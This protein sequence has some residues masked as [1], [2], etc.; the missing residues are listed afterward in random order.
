STTGQSSSTTG[1]SS[2]SIAF[3]IGRSFTGGGVDGAHADT[4]MARQ[5]VWGASIV[6]NPSCWKGPIARRAPE[7]VTPAEISERDCRHYC[8]PDRGDGRG[9]DSVQCGGER[10][11]PS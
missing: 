3:I 4:A 5:T 7:K 6:G 8:S 10:R 11:H 9:S 1:R 2:R